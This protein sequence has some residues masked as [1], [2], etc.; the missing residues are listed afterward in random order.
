MRHKLTP[1]IE[2]VNNYLNSQTITSSFM[3]RA[4]I[5]Y[6]KEINSDFE[7][8][9]QTAVRFDTNTKNNKINLIFWINM[10]RIVTFK[11]AV[12]L[13]PQ[14]VQ[15]IISYDQGSLKRQFYEI[16][17]IRAKKCDKNLIIKI[18][19][20]YLI[21]LKQQ[22]SG[23]FRNHYMSFLKFSTKEQNKM[24]KNI[25]HQH[26]EK[27]VFY[28]SDRPTKKNKVTDGLSRILTYVDV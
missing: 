9:K 13:K 21:L 14:S 8:N 24:I 18:F 17:E 4:S 26:I 23:H 7:I 16:Y 20:L 11:K 3:K 1:I 6:E 10:Y 25:I 2:Q 19:T 12:S 15:K 22:Q 27:R 28:C 5:E